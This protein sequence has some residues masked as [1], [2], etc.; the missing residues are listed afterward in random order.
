MQ[1]EVPLMRPDERRVVDAQSV[2]FNKSLEP[3][4]AESAK[5]T[6]L[7]W[8]REQGKPLRLAYGTA[9][10]DGT[11]ILTKWS[12]IASFADTL[13]IKGRDGVGAMAAVTGVFTDEDLALLTIP[14]EAVE[15]EN[16]TPVK[17]HI[18]DLSL[19]RFLV[20]TRPDGKPGAFGV[21]GVL[22]RNLRET[23]KAH[24]GIMP[25]F[26]YSGAGIRIANVQPEYGAAEAGLRSGDVILQVNERKISGL[27]ELRNALSGKTPGD[28]VKR[29]QPLMEVMSDKATMEVPSPTGGVVRAVAV[30]VGDKI[31]EGSLIL[32]LEGEGAAA[33]TPAAPKVSPPPAPTTAPGGELTGHRATDRRHRRRLG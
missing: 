16:I 7:V 24:L 11:S 5:S 4:I 12:E 23:D 9:V 21:V 19:G 2:D 17:F 1:D 28:K 3:I 31:S 13:Y 10:Q 30:N 8:G 26:Q 27:Q 15:S 22:E 29:A 20:A 32:T 25:D 33:A 6:V 14:Q 18:S